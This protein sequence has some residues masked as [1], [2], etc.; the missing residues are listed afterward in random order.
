MIANLERH[1]HEPERVVSRVTQDS[2]P[3]TTE[4]KY[5]REFFI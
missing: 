2:L 5:L 3:I 1:L 4:V